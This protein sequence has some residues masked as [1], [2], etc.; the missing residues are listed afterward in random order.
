[1]FEVLSLLSAVEF[2]GIGSCLDNL[3]L[4][5][6]D[7]DGAVN[8]NI[9]VDNSLKVVLGKEVSLLQGEDQ[10]DALAGDN[11]MLRGL[12]QFDGIS[13]QGATAIPVYA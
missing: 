6:Y 12:V 4:T 3:V 10:I 11:I 7:S 13:G 9:Q 1:M 2:I 8:T 5:K